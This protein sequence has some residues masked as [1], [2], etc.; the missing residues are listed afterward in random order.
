MA[1]HVGRGGWTWYTGSGG[2]MQRAGVEGILGLRVRGGVLELNPCIPKGWP[3][4]EITLRHHS[5]R[6]E[7]LV[8]NPGGTTQAIAYAEVDG[9]PID[10]RPLRV[11]LLDDGATHHVLARLG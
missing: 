4:F 7:I 5:A 8:E 3:R 1:P 6:Y 10:D 2:W 9:T 11:T